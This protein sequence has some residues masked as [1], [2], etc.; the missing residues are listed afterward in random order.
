MNKTGKLINYL[1]GRVLPGS[2]IPFFIVSAWWLASRTG[3][4]VVPG[5]AE[6]MRVLLH[7]F[8]APPELY[9]RSI[10]F[11]LFMTLIR[12]TAGFGLAIVTAVPLGLLAGQSRTAE[13]ILY[14]VIQMSR[15][16]NPIALM[17][18]ATVFFGLASVASVFTGEMEAWKYDLADQ[19]QLAMIFILWWGGFFPIFLS[20][21]NGVRSVGAPYIEM[22]SLAGASRVQLLKNVIFPHALPSIMHGIRMGMG[23]TWLVLLAAEIYPGTRS[24]IGYMLCTACKTSDYQY[25]FAAMIIIALTG[26]LLDWTIHHF[27][28][29]TGHWQTRER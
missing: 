27:E 7:P 14:P 13:R 26:L 17:P 21:L 24:G 11:S 5:I 10:A 4:A 20:T 28:K 3:T 2:I 19:V 16:I 6:V 25:T 29:K 9:S 12:F 23:I 18:L 22:M 8:E 15:S 1:A